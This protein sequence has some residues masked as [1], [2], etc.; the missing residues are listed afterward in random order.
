MGPV[1]NQD[2]EDRGSVSKEVQ[3]RTEVTT[4]GGEY[5]PPI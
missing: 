2:G 1:G 5:K 3:V 4:E